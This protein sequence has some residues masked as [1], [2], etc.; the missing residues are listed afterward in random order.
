MIRNRLGDK[1]HSNSIYLREILTQWIEARILARTKGKSKDSTTALNTL[2][3]LKFHSDLRAGD[4]TTTMAE[5]WETFRLTFIRAITNALTHG[6]DW[7]ESLAC[8]HVCS[9]ALKTGQQRI[10]SITVT[11]MKDSSLLCNPVLHAMV[12]VAKLDSSF[13]LGVSGYSRE[14]PSAAWEACVSR[15]PGE[16]ALTLVL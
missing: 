9:C 3:A 13:S 15:L 4:D 2:E 6:C 12:I 8:L 11:A 1:W 14:T 10:R 5:G 16:D 7:M